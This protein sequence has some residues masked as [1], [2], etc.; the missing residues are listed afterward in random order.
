M[1]TQKYKDYLE[2]LESTIRD[3][4]LRYLFK[5]FYSDLDSDL[6]KD[7]ILNMGLNLFLEILTMVKQIKPKIGK[8]T[9]KILLGRNTK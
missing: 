9:L 5:C 2:E 7:K 3:E 8:T 1:D 4:S 6:D